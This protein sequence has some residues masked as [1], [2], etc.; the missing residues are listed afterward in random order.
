[1]VIK[2]LQSHLITPREKI[3]KNPAKLGQ[4]VY[5]I[6]SKEHHS[7]QTVEDTIE[8]MTPKYFEELMNAVDKG[9]KD[10][11]S[12]FY[13]VV[14]RKK[15]TIAGTVSN[16][17]HHKY[18]TRQT[19]PMATFLR[20]QWPN[21]DHDLYEVDNNKGTMTL[22]YTLPSAQDA[23]TILKNADCYDPKLVEWIVQ[24]NN[25]RLDFD[26]RTALDGKILHG[27]W[28]NS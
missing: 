18:V 16:V 3:K 14:Q 1:M 2:K 4:A 8:A 20:H 28:P 23:K 10:F 13:I 12:P 15:E 24:Y 22:I 26:P 6:L 7:I 5:D 11:Q 25:G 27:K 17:L 19:R 9:C 21:A